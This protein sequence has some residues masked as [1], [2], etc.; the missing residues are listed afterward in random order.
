MSD[1]LDER[2]E[3]LEKRDI[4]TPFWFWRQRVKTNERR[5]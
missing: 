1:E 2:A 3:Q 4:N 5:Y